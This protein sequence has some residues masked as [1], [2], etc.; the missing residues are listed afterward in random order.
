M[1]RRGAA[2]ALF[3]RFFGSVP[4]TDD[5][6]ICEQILQRPGAGRMTPADPLTHEPLIWRTRILSWR[7]ALAGFGPTQTARAS[8]RA[9]LICACSA[10][11]FRPEQPVTG[12]AQARH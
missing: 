2:H 6:R 12:V 11:V 5:P 4:V 10:L 9:C 3:L 7:A 8:L 1:A